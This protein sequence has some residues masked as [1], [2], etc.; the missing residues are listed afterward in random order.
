[1]KVWENFATLTARL[2]G[3]HA[4][5][6]VLASGCAFKPHFMNV[7]LNGRYLEQW[8]CKS[9]NFFRDLVSCWAKQK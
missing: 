2:L 3:S 5:E 1:M 7:N 6:I 8:T 9:S 4:C